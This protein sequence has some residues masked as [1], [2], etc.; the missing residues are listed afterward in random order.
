MTKT[1][2]NYRSAQS[3][4]LHD[5]EPIE[6]PFELQSHRQHTRESINKTLPA[7]PTSQRN[8]RY[9]PIDLEDGCFTGKDWRD[10][11][12]LT[13]SSLPLHRGLSFRRT[14]AEV[15]STSWHLIQ[16]TLDKLTKNASDFKDRCMILTHD[17]C[18]TKL[19]KNN[20]SHEW[21]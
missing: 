18:C 4:V 20:H 8:T 11:E 10:V 6:L 5:R 3:L 2:E 17:R 14:I 21:R 16:A 9:I 7:V 12:S 15:P 13:S 1:A 19:T